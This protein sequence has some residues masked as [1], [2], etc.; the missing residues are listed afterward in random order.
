MFVR[1]DEL[2]LLDWLRGSSSKEAVYD[3]KSI[4]GM[5]RVYDWLWWK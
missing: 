4:E 2:S 3:W 1:V 5:G